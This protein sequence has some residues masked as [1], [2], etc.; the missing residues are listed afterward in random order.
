VEVNIQIQR[1]SK[2]LHDGQASGL[3][4]AAQLALPR[5]SAKVRA[6][7][8]DECAKHHARGVR[9]IGHLE[10]QG[11]RQGEY[12]LPGRHA[13]KKAI[14]AENRRVGHPAAQTTWTESTP[15]TR[16]RYDSVVSAVFASDAQKAMNRNATTKVRLELVKY[17]G[18]QFDAPCFQIR[19]E[20]RPVLSFA[21]HR[22]GV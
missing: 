6:D 17:E 16:E 7:G 12:V 9:R 11:I 19:H 10:A 22:M 8:A 15:F 21:V 13:G 3:Q 2:S 20:H 1:R 14:H 4:P 18:G 5:A